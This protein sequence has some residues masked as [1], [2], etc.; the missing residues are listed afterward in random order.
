M[1]LGQR[2][3]DA[4]V[5]TVQLTQQRPMLA[6]GEQDVAGALDEASQRAGALGTE[7]GLFERG[8]A[9]HRCQERRQ[10]APLL[11]EAGKLGLTLAHA[12]AQSF[13]HQRYVVVVALY[14]RVWL[15]HRG[16]HD[17][18]SS[19]SWSQRRKRAR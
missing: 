5:E 13:E 16:K 6:A 2:E 18:A 15:G 12:G 9:T 8:V 7:S 1:E 17:I 19:R 4:S 3:L 14:G 11:V 10:L